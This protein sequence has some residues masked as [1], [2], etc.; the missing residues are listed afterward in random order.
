MIADALSILGDNDPWV[1]GLYFGSVV[2]VAAFGYRA[3]VRAGR[4]RGAPARRRFLAGV[5]L[6]GAAS[7]V[8]PIHLFVEVGGLFDA[9]PIAAL[10]ALAAFGVLGVVAAAIVAGLLWL[11]PGAGA[12]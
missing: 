5:L 9:G 3:G 7:L 2:L 8:H 4:K 10:Q 1:L 12:V 11:W 6:G